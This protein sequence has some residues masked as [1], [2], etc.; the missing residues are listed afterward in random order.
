MKAKTIIIKSL[1]YILGLF[2]MAIGV[3]ISLNSGL[4]ITPINSFPYTVSKVINVSLGKMVIVLFIIMLILQIIILKNEFKIYNLSQLL[5]S[6]LFGFFIDYAE[7]FVGDFK[8]PTYF[9]SL[10]MILM[11]V[12]LTAIGFNFYLSVN[13]INMPVEGFIQAVNKKYFKDKTFGDIKMVFD[14]TMVSLAI[15]ISL[16]FLGKIEGIREGTIISAIFVGFF[17]K[18]FSKYIEPIVKKIEQI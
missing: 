2:I 17:V 7:F 9:G 13:L 15:I 5:F 6:T 3:R 8:I 14:I 18:K 10:L 4:G 11:S 1:I 12:L 16:I